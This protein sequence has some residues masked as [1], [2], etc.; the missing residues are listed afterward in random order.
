MIK[1]LLI[2][3]AIFILFKLFMNDR[4]HKVKAEERKEEPPIPTGE[5][6]KD[7]IC[8]AFVS[9]Q[10]DIRVREG[11]LVQCFCSYDCRDKYIK[12]VTAQ[13]AE[14]IKQQVT[15]GQDGQ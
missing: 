15:D 14:V 8:G 4:R 5:M 1:W 2:A 10:S 6:I 3:A 13:D 12:Q 9:K 7:P 11:E